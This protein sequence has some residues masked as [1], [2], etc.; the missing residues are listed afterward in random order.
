MYIGGIDYLYAQNISCRYTETEERK[1][2]N[3]AFRPPL[4]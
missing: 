1:R 4:V 2:T 3:I